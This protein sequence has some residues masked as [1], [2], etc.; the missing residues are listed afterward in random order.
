MKR[1][2]L[3]QHLRLNNCNLLREGGS[4][5]IYINNNNDAISAVPRHPDVRKLMIRKIC[6]ELGINSPSGD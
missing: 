3:L 5:S 4:H 2:K 6:K 1:E